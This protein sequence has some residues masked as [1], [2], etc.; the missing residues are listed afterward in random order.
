[1]KLIIKNSIILCI[2]SFFIYINTK[3][4]YSQVV[5][6]VVIRLPKDYPKIFKSI[7]ISSNDIVNDSI[8]ITYKKEYEFK[9]KINGNFGGMDF[10]YIDFENE[11][12]V[13]G[14]FIDGLD[15]LKRQVMFIDFEGNVNNVVEKYL[16][17][18]ENGVWEYYTLKGKFI[19]KRFYIMGGE[20]MKW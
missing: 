3:V 19:R 11:I 18:Y 14:Q 15:T 12:R 4:L 9:S 10:L 7:S 17:P 13:T 5:I 20:V 16:I 6:E 1:M 8:N 2:F